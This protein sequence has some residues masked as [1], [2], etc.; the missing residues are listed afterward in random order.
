MKKNK[1]Q[2]LLE[3]HIA[4]DCNEPEQTQLA[5]LVESTSDDKLEVEL[6]QLFNKYEPTFHFSQKEKKK[7]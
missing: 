5:E 7:S 3:K 1:I 2:E 6:F 4:S